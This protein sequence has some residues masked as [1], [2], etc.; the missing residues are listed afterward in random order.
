MLQQI[1][2]KVSGWVAKVIFVLVAAAFIFWGLSY[3]INSGSGAGQKAAKVNG[4]VITKQEVSQLYSRMSAQYQQMAKQP[5]T[6]AMQKML[7][8]QA[9][10]ELI[11]NTLMT[12]GLKDM[13]LVVSSE[14]LNTLIAQTKAFQANG[15]FSPGRYLQILAANGL[16]QQV[17][18][19]RLKDQQR[20][21]QFEQGII[22][23]SFVL[24]H[25]VTTSYQLL[26]QSRDFGYFTI[27]KSRFKPAKIS[28]AQIKQYYQAHQSDYQIPEKVKVNYLLISPKAIMQKITV[29]NQQVLDYYNANKQNFLTPKSY[30][31]NEITVSGKDA[32]KKMTAI[33]KQLQK[34]VAFTKAAK[35]KQ[36][37]I[38]LGDASKSLQKILPTM[39]VGQISVPFT[40]KAGQHLVQ[41]IAVKPG[42]IRL[43]ASVKKNIKQNLQSQKAQNMFS[44][45]S[46]QLSNLTFTH[47]NSLAPA[48]KALGVKEKTSAWFTQAGGKTKLFKNADVLK[49]AF[50]SNVIQGNN[51][52]VLTLANG[53]LMVLRAAGHQAAGV[54]PLIS[55]QKQITKTL[56]S[57]AASDQAAK[58]AGAI[59]SMMQDGTSAKQIAKQYGLK[60]VVKKGVSNLD[61]S[62]NSTIKSAAFH[63]QLH[64]PATQVS[65][66]ALANNDYAVVKLLGVHM[67]KK[68]PNNPGAKMLPKQITQSSAQT[69]MG[70]YAN[71]LKQQAK[72]SS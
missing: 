31:V 58:L 52:D 40:D 18:E 36:R 12:M 30:Q 72:I 35:S 3:Y 39:Q 64:D 37:D 14:T 61:T 67:V 55:V 22:A 59:A 21:Q 20:M 62:I 11:D 70:L 6:L 29:T 10:Q 47:P 16:T 13:G 54:K 50:S 34:G 32:A 9:L 71:G 63:A 65:D 42:H 4:V 5:L 41:L 44:K 66:V 48:A 1:H 8:K 38:E 25:E 26:H 69:V 60:W 45:K 23:S 43:F 19:A 33:V 7:R 51:S 17:Y 27:S 56:Q 68:L 28:D 24:P 53:D 2:K 57:Q 46:D 49:A 15:Q